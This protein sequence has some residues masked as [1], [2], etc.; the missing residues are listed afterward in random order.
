MATHDAPAWTGPIG[1]A[2]HAAKGAVYAAV[3]ILAGKAAIG[4]GGATTG[5]KG[6]IQEIGR[7]P[8][9]RAMLIL[10]AAGLA[11]Y[12]AW[13]FLAAFVDAEGR[14]TDARGIGA[15]LGSFVSGLIHVG[16]ALAAAT[17]LRGSGG[18]DA[19]GWTAKL[20]SA[21]F[22]PWL[23]VATG[24]AVGAAGVAQWV[25]AAK[26]SYRRKFDLDGAAASQRH[27]IER[28]AKLGLAARGLVFLIIG[29]FLASA[30]WHS[31]ASQARGF[32]EALDTL[33][34][35]PFGMWLLGI[36]ALGLICYGIYCF[37]VAIYAD[38]GASE[39][40]MFDSP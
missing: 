25:F 20:M 16:L 34:R 18:E 10:L 2:G 4:I 40:P 8:F 24:V 3:G 9:G 7:Q 11:C 12:A 14:G 35:Q 26:G 39:R 22:G 28:A 30:G 29:F 1:R 23:V 17:A 19:Q 33:A 37:I 31:D 38:L 32:G 27:W 15:R 5:S 36:T 21:P 13:R 6:A